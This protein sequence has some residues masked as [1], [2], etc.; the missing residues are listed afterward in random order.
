M[1]SFD[2]E[3]IIDLGATKE[4]IARFEAELATIQKEMNGY[5]EELG[6]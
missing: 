1:D 3:E 2:E 6:L 4:E 5:L